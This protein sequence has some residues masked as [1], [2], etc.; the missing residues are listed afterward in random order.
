M[1]WNLFKRSSLFQH[2]TELESST[3]SEQLERLVAEFDSAENVTKS[4]QQ[5]AKKLLD[6][7]LCMGKFETKLTDELSAANIFENDELM[8]SVIEEW[9][10]FAFVSNTIGDEYV[11][12][13][14]KTLIEPLKQ[15][16]QAFADL[17]VK[18]RLHDAIQLDVIKFQRKL[19]SYSEH[20][21]TGTNL[22]KMKRVEESL[23]A[24]RKEL[25][26]QT[27]S[28][29]DD[30]SHFLTGSIEMLTP[31]LEGFIAAEVAW[32]RACNRSMDSRSQIAST[33]EMLTS[34]DRMKNIEDS[35]RALGVLSICSD[36][37]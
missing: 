36:S 26:Y 1:S 14:Q 8:K 9:H 23:N 21:K 13:L 4:L 3:K 28:L 29:V 33:T 19:A 25:A 15:L 32:V 10:S 7:L 12:S 20:E 24:S 16:K 31:L 30:L 34:S 27:K 11:I 22:V 6:Q 2:R 35:F 37:K 17:R 5:S 18:I